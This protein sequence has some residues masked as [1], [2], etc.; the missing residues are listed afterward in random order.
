MSY[1]VGPFEV[2]SGALAEP[3]RCR[4]VHLFPAIAT[5][6]SDTMDGVFLVNGREVTVAI[7]CAALARLRDQENSVFTDQQLAETAARHLQRRLEDGYDPAGTEL[8]VGDVD[9]R[10]LGHEL[11]FF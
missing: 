10:A 7:S 1:V 2:A 11:G 4:F 9:L 5:R 8:M 3:V 6:H